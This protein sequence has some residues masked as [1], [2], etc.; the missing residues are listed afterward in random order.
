MAMERGRDRV[1]A[2]DLDKVRATH[3]ALTPLGFL[4]WAADVYGGRTGC[5]YGQERRSWAE[6]RRRCRR[7]ASG[8]RGLGV[9]P[10]DT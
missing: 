7:L 8:L 4:D 10:G 9:R 6:I 2:R 1:D 5:I 3:Q